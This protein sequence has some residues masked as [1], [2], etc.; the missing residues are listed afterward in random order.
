MDVIYYI[1]QMQL[2]QG[3]ESPNNRILE[4]MYL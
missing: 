3:A 4:L 1:V 2:F